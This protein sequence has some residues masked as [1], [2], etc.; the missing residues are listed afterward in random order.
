[1]NI[2]LTGSGGRE[3]ALAWKI[4]RSSKITQLFIAPGNPGTAKCGTNVDID[5]NDFA[6]LGKFALQNEVKM[7]V[8]GPEEPLANGIVDYFAERD[9]LKHIA[10]IGPPKLGAMLESSKDY[11]KAFMTR[12]RIPTA[13]YAS[14]DLARIADG[15]RFLEHLNPPYVLKADGLAAGK[16]VIITESLSEATLTL[17]IMLEGQFGKASSTVVIEEYLKGIEVSVFVLTDGRSYKLLP[18][19]KDYK[20]ISEH[21]R[22]LNT[23]GMGAVSPVDFADAEFMKKVRDRI[24]EPTLTGLRNEGIDYKGFI[25]FGLINCTG[26]PYVIEYNVRLGDPETEVIMP[27]LNADLVDL[28]EGVA[29]NRLKECN[30]GIAPATALT[31]VAASKGYPGKYKIGKRISTELINDDSIHLFHSGTKIDSHGDLVTAGGRVFALTAVGKN[32]KDAQDKAYRNI[33]QI[34]YD[35]R[36]YR[37]DIGND[38]M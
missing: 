1:M 31:V 38:V 5:V 22:G 12:Y 7:I 30:C 10:L 33:E 17:S 37:R 35:G 9:E 14:F 34:S 28:F 8:V 2:L 19:A 4:S 23:G 29:Q 24:I 26:E 18:E 15:I 25:F 32:V 21:D 36:Y 11:A 13:R 6:A 3:H 27:R 20:R 16:G